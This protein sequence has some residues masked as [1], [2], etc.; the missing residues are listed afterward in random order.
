MLLS[1]WQ[2]R[3]EDES[4]NLNVSKNTVTLFLEIYKPHFKRRLKKEVFKILS[5]E[6]NPISLERLELPIKTDLVVW[7]PLSEAQKALY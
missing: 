7:V 1:M 5:S 2:L 3:L 4:R 6:L